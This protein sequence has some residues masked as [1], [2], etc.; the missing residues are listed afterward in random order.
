MNTRSAPSGPIS[1]ITLRVVR[2]AEIASTRTRTRER[3]DSSRPA[4]VLTAITGIRVPG[5]PSEPLNGAPRSEIT[6]SAPAPARWASAARLRNV[7]TPRRAS[8]TSP[9]RSPA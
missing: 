9:R 1:P 5:P 7:H 6:S 8:A 4:R 2:L 3:R